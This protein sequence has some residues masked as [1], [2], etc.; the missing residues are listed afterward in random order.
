LNLIRL[1][2]LGK[3]WNGLMSSWWFRFFVCCH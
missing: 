3:V 2:E 1:L